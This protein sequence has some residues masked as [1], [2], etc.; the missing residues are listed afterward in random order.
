MIS[1][2]LRVKFLSHRVKT[3]KGYDETFVRAQCA[4]N[5]NRATLLANNYQIHNAAHCNKKFLKSA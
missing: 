1:L 4:R 3:V 5:K 2:T